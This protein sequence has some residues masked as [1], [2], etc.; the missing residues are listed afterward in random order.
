MKSH[1]VV[2]PGQQPLEKN[3]SNEK[4]SGCP[5]KAGSGC[6]FKLKVTAVEVMEEAENRPLKLSNE[7]YLKW[8]Y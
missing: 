4:S 6:P 5:M 1:P 8:N 3:L 7:A 2:V